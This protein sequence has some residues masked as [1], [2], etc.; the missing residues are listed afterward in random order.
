MSEPDTMHG[1]QSSHSSPYQTSSTLGMRRLSSALS[2]PCTPIAPKS[3]DRKCNHAGTKSQSGDG[4]GHTT[5]AMKKTMIEWIEIPKNFSLL[6]GSATVGKTLVAGQKL[7]KTDGYALLATAVNAEHNVG[8]ESKNAKNRWNTYHAS[9]VKTRTQSQKT[10]FGVTDTDKTK[11]INTVEE[12]LE[13]LCPFFERLDR[14]FGHRQNI[15]PFSV[16]TPAI[17]I[18][19]SD[20][21]RHVI[22]NSVN[23]FHV[24]LY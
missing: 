5:K 17:P 4:L 18:N 24:F 23:V 21:D 3:N 11:G 16:L 22:L 1:S 2:P 19:E 8:W 7:R 20:E 6:T 15:N 14:L 12:K 13:S 9:Y 10:G